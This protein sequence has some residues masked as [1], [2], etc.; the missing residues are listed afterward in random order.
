MPKG[1]VKWFNDQ[2]GYGFVTPEGL[3]LNQYDLLAKTRNGYFSL[4]EKE[5]R[6]LER[7]QKMDKS[8]LTKEQRKKLEQLYQQLNSDKNDETILFMAKF[9]K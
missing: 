4:V 5:S 8:K 9:K 2:K 7:I 1:K 3:L 6:I